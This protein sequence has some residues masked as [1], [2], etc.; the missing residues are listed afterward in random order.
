MRRRTTLATSDWVPV[1]TTLPTVL[2]DYHQNSHQ[3]DRNLRNRQKSR[4]SKIHLPGI[5]LR[6]QSPLPRP[7][8]LSL[9]TK[10]S[11]SRRSR[12]Q[13]Q[14]RMLL[15]KSA[16]PMSLQILQPPRT[17]DQQANRMVTG[18]M[19][20]P[21]RPIPASL[22]LNTTGARMP[23]IKMPKL[24]VQQSLTHLFRVRHQPKMVPQYRRKAIDEYR[25]RLVHSLDRSAK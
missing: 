20:H 24:P 2:R 22:A 3:R 21:A 7:R 5:S 18:P 12:R 13:R 6:R 10:E 14:R 19:L 15:R 11:I 23:T 9:R 25:E 4:S 8:P 17:P 16:T 1:R